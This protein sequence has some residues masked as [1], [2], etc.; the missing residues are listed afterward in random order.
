MFHI[1]ITNSATDSGNILAGENDQLPLDG[2]STADALRY[3]E[4]YGG[5]DYFPEE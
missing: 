1:H 5:E 2:C 4:E 3:M